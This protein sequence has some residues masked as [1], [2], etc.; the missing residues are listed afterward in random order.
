[1]GLSVTFAPGAASFL[2][3]K[4]HAAGGAPAVVIGSLVTS[5]LLTLLV[6]PSIYP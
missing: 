5:T 2:V 3:S 6:L 1:L 4:E